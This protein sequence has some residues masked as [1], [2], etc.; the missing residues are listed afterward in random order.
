M[1]VWQS[2]QVPSVDPLQPDD[3]NWLELHGLHIAQ[4]ASSVPL[5]PL[6]RYFPESQVTQLEQTVSVV[7]LQP[8]VFYLSVSHVV[9]FEQTVSVSSC[10]H[11]SSTCRSRMMH[12]LGK[13]VIGLA[14]AAQAVF[15]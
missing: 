13:L 12:S 1:Q 11:C 7:P 6:E 9:Q 10:N 14:A 4:K 15:S 3:Q 2:L 8:P 5:Q